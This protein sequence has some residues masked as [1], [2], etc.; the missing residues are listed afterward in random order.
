M[1]IR[2]AILAALAGAA[3]VGTGAYA[4]EVRGSQTPSNNPGSPKF[5]DGTGPTG[6]SNTKTSP[7]ARP[8]S[9]D[10][11]APVTGSGSTRSGTTS[12]GA[13]TG[14]S[15]GESGKDVINRSRQNSNQ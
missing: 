11:S 3:L 1:K 4:Q 6:E 10:T 8:N 2:T 12:G 7:S 14:T 5:Q 15:G 13:S 9:S